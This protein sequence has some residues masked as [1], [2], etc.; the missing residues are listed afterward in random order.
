ME[1]LKEFSEYMNLSKTE[2]IIN[3]KYFTGEC[4]YQ[5]KDY[6]NALK[7]FDNVIEINKRKI[8]E[9]EDALNSDTAIAESE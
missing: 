4:L 3:A 7:I 1:T 6:K 5:L 9:P 8:P 2:K